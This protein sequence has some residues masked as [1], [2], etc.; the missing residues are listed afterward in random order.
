MSAIPFQNNII[1]VY[2]E[3]DITDWNA[4]FGS[5]IRAVIHKATEGLYF[6]DGT[7]IARQGAAKAAGLMWG[8]YHFLTPQNGIEQ[9]NY[10]LDFAKPDQ[11]ELVAVDVEREGTAFD[12]LCDFV[13][14]IHS[15]LGRYPVV[16][17]SNVLRSLTAGHP[18]DSSVLHNCPLWIADYGSDSP[19]LPAPWSFWTLWQYTDGTNS[20]PGF[21]S[22]SVPGINGAVLRDTFNIT[23]KPLASYWPNI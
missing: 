5:G 3:T 2:H 18:G 8:S 1:D 19:Q 10:Y 21:G 17:G 13:N 14:Q 11:D 4:I 20:A 15:K 7:F 16:Y 23:D 22:D 6:K 12:V 9:A